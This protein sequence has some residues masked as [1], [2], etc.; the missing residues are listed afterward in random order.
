MVVSAPELRAQIEALTEETVVEVTGTVTAN[1]TAPA[2]V[3]IVEATVRELSGPTEPPPFDIYR[4]TL[5]AALPTLLDHA[6][7]ALRHPL[8]RPRSGCPPRRSAAFAPHWTKRASWRCTPRRSWHRRPS[9]GANVFAIDY[10][11]RPAFLAQSPQFYKQMLV[12]V[13]ERVYEVGPVFR[14]EPHDTVRHLAQ[15]TSLDV[16]LGFIADHHDVMAVLRDVVAGMVAGVASRA[17]GHWRRGVSLP[18][19]PA[20]IP[21]VHFA[22]RWR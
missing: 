22:E 12:G 5:K 6:P 21:S 9:R 17:A 8:R 19:V 20:Q 2:G 13:F 18:E 10:F 7:V 14:A 4:P 3:E 16:E 1:P 15:Y 11:G